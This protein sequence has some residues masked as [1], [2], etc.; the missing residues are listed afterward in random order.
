M[1]IPLRRATSSIEPLEA[2]YAP[3]L[4]VVNPIADIVA[5]SGKTSAMVELSQLFDATVA[6][7]GHTLVTFTTNFDADANTPGIQPSAPFVIE[8]FDDKAPL[9]TQ[10]FLSYAQNPNAAAD[11]TNTFFHRAV[12]NFVIQGGGFDASN[13]DKHIAVGPEVHN[14]FGADRSNL[15]GTV[16]M[17]K[18]GLGPHTATSEWFVNLKD[19]SGLNTQNGGFTVF[20]RVIQNLELFDK[21]AALQQRDFGGALSD[22]PVQN[23]SLDPDNNP[24]TPAPEP[25]SKQLIRITNVE[26]TPPVPGNAAGTTFVVKSITDATTNAPTDLLTAKIGG[27][28][29]AALKLKYAPGEAGVANVTITATRNGE[30]V[31]E[32]FQVKVLPNLIANVDGDTLPSIIASGDAANVVVK[33]TNNAAG[34]LATNVDVKFYLSKTGPNDTNGSILDPSDRL[35]GQL[36][37]QPISIAGGA[38]LDLT[39]QVRIPKEIAAVTGAH[40][41][42]AEVKT[43]AGST[44]T[45]LFTDDNNAI[46]GDLHSLVN[47]FGEVAV[48]NFGSRIIPKF[49]YSEA[50]GDK[51]VLRIAGGGTATLTRDG[52]DIDLRVAGTHLESVL[53]AETKAGGGRIAIEDINITDPIGTVGFSRVDSDGFINVSEGVRRLELGSLSGGHTLVLG[54]L[55]PDNTTPATIKLRKVID[56]SLESS[57]PIAS[58]TARQWLDTTG[59]DDRILAPSLGRLNITGAPANGNA[60]AVAGDFEANLIVDRGAIGSI[61]IAGFLRNA[62]VTLAK[63]NIGTV[64]LGGMDNADFFVGTTSRPDSASDFIKIRTIESFTVGEN[65]TGVRFR[66]SQVA[67]ANFGTI[68]VTGVDGSSG[69][70]P[71]GFVADKVATYKRTAGPTGTNL[72]TPQTFDPLTNYSLTIL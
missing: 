39:G 41:I 20:G 14:E 40:R 24:N 72:T 7:P 5:G 49:I 60:P 62:T 4:V 1:T 64:S 46:D 56:V 68:S 9:T 23:Y 30:S 28:N 35:I 66:D 27:E 36:T 44:L 58:L 19:N 21:I 31:D 55:L 59:A 18:T 45:E 63:S 69:S 53:T 16:A 29:N 52:A 50:D 37:G 42:L 13:I 8:L 57:Q 33:L 32:T 67:A 51:V 65:D 70:A 10:N 11:Y 17:A 25:T 3:A 15:R 71:F 22:L 2:R 26:V 12:T 6:H 61:H 34:Q 48:Q 38:S 47:Q 54:A 43:S